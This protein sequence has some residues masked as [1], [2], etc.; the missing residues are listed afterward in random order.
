M[1]SFSLLPAGIGRVSACLVLAV[2]AASWAPA[3]RAESLWEQFSPLQFHG[4]MELRAGCRTQA[5]D[6]EKD[7]SVLETRLQG[8]LSTSTDWARFKY[9]GDVWLD[10]VLEKVVYDTR[11]AWMLTRP[12]DE[13]D[14]K[15][16]R[17]VLTWGT[18]DLVFINDLFPKDWQ[19]FYIGRDAEY[20]KAPSDSVKA[21]GFF[22]FLDLDL[23][24]TPR[25]AA[26]RFITGEY[27]SYWN[28][29]D[30]ALA[31]SD[32][33]LEYDELDDWFEDDEV[34]ARVYRTL[35]AYEV[36]LYGYWGFWKCPGGQDGAGTGV[37]PGLD[38]YGGSVRGPVGP[39]I[40]NV[41][42]GYYRSW[43]DPN[44]RDPL[45]NNSEMRYLAGYTQEIVRNFTGS[46]QYYVEQILDYDGY[47]M[48]ANDDYVRDEWRHVATLQLTW[49]LMNQNLGLS[50]EGYCSPSDR[51][52]Y[53]RPKV[54]YKHTDHLTQEIG[55]NIF[56]GQGKHTT[57]GQHQNDTNVYMAL[58]YS[59]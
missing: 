3:C 24:Y 49:L 34:A 52:A 48:D 12:L 8:E 45:I 44:G 58:R 56:L 21:S 11:E 30:Q 59:F 5:D 37:F 2:L 7:A 36:A 1:T 40:G 4:F 13:I 23:V 33:Q 18:G 15:V 57:F 53:L 9:K 55:A 25:F 19:S 38:V 41:E 54:S 14:L 28:G 17:Q 27:V 35:G 31:G 43:E 51:D 10:G 50:L 46:A 20:L 47:R 39:G 29:N 22:G 16:G 42:I 32:S 26:D 6:H